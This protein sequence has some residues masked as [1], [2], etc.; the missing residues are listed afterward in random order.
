M[1][2]TISQAMTDLRTVFGKL[3]AGFGP[4]AGRWNE[5][6]CDRNLQPWRKPSAKSARASLSCF[7]RCS[8]W[9][10]RLVKAF[11]NIGQSIRGWAAVKR[12]DLGFFEFSGMNADEL[13]DWLKKV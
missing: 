10:A 12:G 3:I 6:D 1:Q 9:Q 11:G 13:D 5:P 8:L 4:K 2:P 7:Q